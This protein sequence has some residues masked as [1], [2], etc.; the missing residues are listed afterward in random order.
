MAP[1]LKQK[2]IDALES[3]KFRLCRGT[4][5]RHILETVDNKPVYATLHCTLGVLA[6]ISGVGRDQY[7]C[8]NVGIG[9]FD[10]LDPSLTM[11][12]RAAIAKI[13]DQPETY[14]FGPTAQYIK[15]NL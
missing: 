4:L 1:D 15:D 11:D 9:Y 2:W 13:N 12:V 6:E 7:G 3:G 14:D 8:L 10:A 5:S